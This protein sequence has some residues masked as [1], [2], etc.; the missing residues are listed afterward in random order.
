MVL[1]VTEAGL[2]VKDVIVLI[3]RQSG[4]QE[5]LSERDLKL[6]AVFT[7][8]EL[9]AIWKDN[10]AITGEQAARVHAFLKAG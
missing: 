6:H 8:T 7:L 1:P 5:A 4:A 2:L 3:D 10:G 9:L